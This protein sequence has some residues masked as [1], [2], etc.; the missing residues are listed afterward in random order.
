MKK[1]NTSIVFAVFIFSCASLYGQSFLSA[2]A[3][4]GGGTIKGN[5]PAQTSYTSSVFIETEMPFVRD[6]SLRISFLYA[7]D[8]NSILPDNRII[9]TPSIKG[10]S[11]KTIVRQPLQDKFYL[12]E[13]IGILLLNDRTFSDT[14]VL[15][16]GAAASFLGGIDF[17]NEINV[18]GFRFG[19][20]VEYGLTFTNTLAG[21]ISFHLQGEYCF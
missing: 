20:G 18:K 2:G 7:A 5:S 16:F 9:Y 10:I 3:S 21:Y 8:I 6:A 11:L 13:G 17:R 1:R 19:A 4:L 14:N 15:D 12:E